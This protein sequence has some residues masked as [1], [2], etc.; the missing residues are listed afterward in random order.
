MISRSLSGSTSQQLVSGQG[1]LTS[2]MAGSQTVRIYD[3]DST[4]GTLIG[5]VRLFDNGAGDPDKVDFS[6]P[7]QFND[8]LFVSVASTTGGV[9][10]MGVI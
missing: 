8:G 5:L 7:V 6:H 9:F 4:S 1:L 10:R 2:V 3:G